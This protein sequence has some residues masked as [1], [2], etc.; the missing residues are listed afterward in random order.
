MYVDVVPMV[1]V[2][3]EEMMKFNKYFY[4]FSIIFQPSLLN[5]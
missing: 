2:L 4:Y 3:L 1:L 5:H